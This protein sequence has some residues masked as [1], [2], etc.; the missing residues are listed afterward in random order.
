MRKGRPYL[1][2]GRAW[3][4]VG[5]VA[6]LL[7]ADEAASGRAAPS[8]LFQ[9]AQTWGSP[10]KVNSVASR[11]MVKVSMPGCLGRTRRKATPSRR[12]GR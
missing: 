5:E 10:G 3:E 8:A 12:R 6:P 4:F 7:R 2:R 1:R 9:P 11:V